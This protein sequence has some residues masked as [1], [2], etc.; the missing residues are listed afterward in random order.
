MAD[1]LESTVRASLEEEKGQL[2]DQLAELAGGDFDENFA[3]SG[4]VAAEQGEVQALAASLREQ[5]DAVEGALAKLD[6]GTYGVCE[7]CQKPIP[8]ARLEAMP[9]SRY[10]I[11]HA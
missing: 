8:D 1:S 6:E 5:L 10:C 2:R 3:D 11:E 7:R 4:Q 9:A